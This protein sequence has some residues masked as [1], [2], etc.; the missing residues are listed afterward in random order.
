[1]SSSSEDFFNLIDHVPTSIFVLDVTADAIPVYAHYNAYA[2]DRL[3]REL[4]EF[5]G[6]TT[7]EVFGEQY[8]TAAYTE[9][10]KTI[11]ARKTRE[12]EFQLPL[13]N[14]V[15]IVR[16]TLV[17]QIAPSG[18]VHRLI[19]SAHDVSLEWVAESA[20]S[21]LKNMGSEVEQF[22][23]MAAHGPVTV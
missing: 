23:A 7:I 11:M 8:G 16:T 4:S 14:E 19:G 5:V 10:R 13:G 6:K 3:G 18:K 22:I 15:R 12:Y 17:P 21:K 1:M 9:Q 20:Q 2:L